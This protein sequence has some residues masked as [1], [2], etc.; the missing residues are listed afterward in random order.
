MKRCKRERVERDRIKVT[1]R[2]RR[3]TYAGE[4]RRKS[5]MSKD[6]E[7]KGGWKT[8]EEG[9]GKKDLEKKLTVKQW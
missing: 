3:E 5:K 6:G 2:Q 8:E 9:G 7:T 1:E 4:A